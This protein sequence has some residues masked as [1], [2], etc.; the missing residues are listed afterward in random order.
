[1]GASMRKVLGSVV[2]MAVSLFQSTRVAFSTLTMISCGLQPEVLEG[3][4]K[5]TCD[6]WS[7]G[8]I[9]VSYMKW[10][11]GRRVL[12]SSCVFRTH[13]STCY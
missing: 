7:L 1:M 13:S 8:V 4:Y 5:E 6:M 2:Y 11:D 9:M 12:T 10:N 3:N